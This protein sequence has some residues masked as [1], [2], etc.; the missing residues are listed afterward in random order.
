MTGPQ[1][2]LNEKVL[3]RGG[4]GGGAA[5]VSIDFYARKAVFY[6]VSR[7]WPWAATPLYVV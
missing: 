1:W 5:A 7:S 2:V 3:P 6:G 4:T